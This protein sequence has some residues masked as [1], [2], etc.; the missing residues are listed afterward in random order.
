MNKIESVIELK[1]IQMQEVIRVLSLCVLDLY[2]CV[3]VQR[4]AAY[5]NITTLE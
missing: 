2:F 1:K 3:Y 4:T 5:I